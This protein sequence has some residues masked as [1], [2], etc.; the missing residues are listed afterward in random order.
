MALLFGKA[1]H[2]SEL[3]PNDVSSQSE[4][5]RVLKYTLN[6]QVD[7]EFMNFYTAIVQIRVSRALHIFEESSVQANHTEKILHLN[8]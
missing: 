4:K 7:L 1:M 5:I 2:P 6:L 8:F 3:E